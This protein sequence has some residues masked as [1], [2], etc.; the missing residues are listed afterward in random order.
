MATLDTKK[1]ARKTLKQC[2]GF[3]GPKRRL[4]FQEN[5]RGEKRERGGDGEERMG[6][7]EMMKWMSWEK[8]RE[9]IGAD[10]EKGSICGRKG[11]DMG[12]SKGPGLQSQAHCWVPSLSPTW[13]LDHLFDLPEVHP[14]SDNWMQ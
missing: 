1:Q 9:R 6:K 11:R 5:G 13:V 12:L 14:S 10:S 7:M 2:S 8:K 3:I 4:A